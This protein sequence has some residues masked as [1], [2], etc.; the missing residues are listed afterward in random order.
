MRLAGE[1]SGRLYGAVVAK[2][3]QAL[4]GATRLFL[5]VV[6]PLSIGRKVLR[7]GDMRRQNNGEKE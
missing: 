5:H 7:Q 3:A 1:S 4:E 6:D 2:P